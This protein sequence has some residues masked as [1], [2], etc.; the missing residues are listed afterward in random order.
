[1]LVGGVGGGS[2]ADEAGGGVAAFGFDLPHLENTGHIMAKV[3][4]EHCPRT[5]SPVLHQK[6]ANGIVAA[7]ARAG[8]R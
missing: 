1:M 7:Y 5:M 2:G 6:G 8:I 4:G 3:F